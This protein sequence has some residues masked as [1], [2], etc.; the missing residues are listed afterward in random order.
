MLESIT[1]GFIFVYAVYW[2]FGYRT[3]SGTVNL[4]VE[5]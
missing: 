2:F 1:L 5:A 3:S 4:I